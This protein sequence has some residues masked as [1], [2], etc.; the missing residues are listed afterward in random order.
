MGVPPPPGV[1]LPYQK[2][3]SITTGTVLLILGA[4]IWNTLPDEM[5]Y[6]KSMRASKRKLESLNLSIDF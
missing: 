6:E 4:R 1:I 3:K 5:K 2:L